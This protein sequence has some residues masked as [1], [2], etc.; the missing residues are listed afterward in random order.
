MAYA[1][2]VVSSERA[3]TLG[4][5]SARPPQEEE[6]AAIAAQLPDI[7]EAITSAL[8]AASNFGAVRHEELADYFVPS[9]FREAAPLREPSP[10]GRTESMRDRIRAA[11]IA[12]AKEAV[13]EHHRAGR[14][15]S[16]L[17]DGE[18]VQ[19]GPPRRPA[20]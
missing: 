20:K 2:A 17:R 1:L 10:T 4:N 9:A 18:I 16:I 14:S 15:V 11:G 6:V 19:V 12:A 3:T 7:A 5:L 8:I 13:A